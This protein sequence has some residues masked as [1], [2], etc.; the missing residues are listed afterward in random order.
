MGLPKATRAQI[1]WDGPD[2]EARRVLDAL[3]GEEGPVGAL[4]LYNAAL[5]LWVT[6][7]VGSIKDGVDRAEAALHSGAALSLVGRLRRLV[8]AGTKEEVT[9]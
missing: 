8:P 7:G 9:A 2:D 5:R 1:P 3:A 4:I 6:D